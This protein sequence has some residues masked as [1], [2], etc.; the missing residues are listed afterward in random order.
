MNKQQVFSL[1]LAN[2]NQKVKVKRYIDNEGHSDFLG[3][4]EYELQGMILKNDVIVIA[5]LDELKIPDC[6]LLLKDIADMSEGDKNE[7]YS[8]DGAE[9]VQGFVD[10]GNC[11]WTGEVSSFLWLITHGYCLNNEWFTN[12]T[13]EK[14]E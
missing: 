5:D 9:M 7:L 13:A 11:S 1:Y 3:E 2:E 10:F 14:G 12:G 8:I 6:T 4:Y